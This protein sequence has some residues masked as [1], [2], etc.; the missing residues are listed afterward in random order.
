M[1]NLANDTAFLLHLEQAS[2]EELRSLISQAQSLLDRRDRQRKKEAEAKIQEIAKAHGLT[3]NVTK[4][5]K[6][7]R[8]SK[9]A[10]A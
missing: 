6:R 7:G 1:N 3:V 8:P 5:A 9:K 4:Q 10:Q 2:D